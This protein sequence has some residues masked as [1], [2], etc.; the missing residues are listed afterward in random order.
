M[1][2]VQA[3]AIGA[4]IATA[5]GDGEQALGLLHDAVAALPVSALPAWGIDELSLAESAVH[6]ANGHPEAA[7]A[8]L[9]TTPGNRPEHTVAEARALLALGRREAASTLPAHLA[10]DGTVS[11]TVLVRVRLLQAAAAAAADHRREAARRLR[12][13]LRLA[14]PEALSR[15][16]RDFGGPWLRELV[17]DDPHLA[18]SYPWLS[19]P[20]AAV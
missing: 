18:V 19:R 3:A 20:R 1:A 2:A 14:R 9:G 6:L 13:A 5:T 10:D 8:V 17:G 7:L 15:T 16:F 4:R 11:P 12:E